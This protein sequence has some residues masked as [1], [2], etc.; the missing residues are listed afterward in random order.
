MT[1]FDHNGG[2]LVLAT[3]L[4]VTGCNHIGK[5]SAR[6]RSPDDPLSSLSAQT[7]GSNPGRIV[8]SNGRQVLLRGVN[9][10]THVDY[11]Q[12]RPDFVTKFPFTEKDADLMAA[13]GWNMVRVCISWSKVEPKPG[14][15]DEAYLDEVSLTVDKLAARGIYTLLDL[16]QDAWGATLAAPPGAEYA[17]GR[18]AGGWDG[19]PGWATFDDGVDRT[20]GKH[21]EL[22][23]AVLVAWSH[24]FK[25][26]AGP[27]GVGIRDRYVAMFGHLVKRFAGNPAVAG[28]DVM[29]EPNQFH[30]ETHPVL[31]EF[32]A[33]ALKAMRAA[34]QEVGAPKRLFFFEPSIAWHAVGFPP[35]APFE[36][37]D[38]VVYSPH[39][40]QEGINDGKLEDAF[41]R[42]ARESVELYK[43]APVV[44]S[45]WGGS[46]NRAQDPEDDY[47]ERHLRE[48]DRYL[49]GAI[50]WTWHTSSGDPHAYYQAREGIPP[51]A[52]WGFFNQNGKDNTWDGMRTEYLETIRK[53]AVRFAP[54]PLD[55]VEW[56][57]DN[58]AIAASGAGAPAGNRL[59]VFIPTDN[60]ASVA[61]ES[62]GLGSVE[63]VPWFGGTLF[64]AP[65]EGGG[66]SARFERT[67][68]K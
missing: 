27:D 20:E 30:D 25:N 58:S 9:V 37:D 63:S 54:G 3:A 7:D 66:W 62:S 45:E 68:V 41:A 50:I 59:E 61:I 18:A 53:M 1:G 33:D 48:Q 52:T 26:T 17:E 28:Y 43:G 55:K 60:P 13:M 42:A 67:S 40:Y 8:D 10:N 14:E 34:E 35:P 23:P 24:F 2:L 38:Q 32:Y 16:H 49:F 39:L 11:W 44:T 64:S 31:S 15:Y 4:A 56:S 46:P 57:K 65:A 12:Y 36:H 29:N 22:N 5:D 19:A 21:R 51:S 6:C 47:F